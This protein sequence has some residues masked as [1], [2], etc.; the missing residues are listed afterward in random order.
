MAKVIVSRPSGLRLSKEVSV[1]ARITNGEGNILLVRQATGRRFWTL[2][3]G[4]VKRGEGLVDALRREVQEESGLIVQIG[5]L[6]AVRD[7][8]EK[9]AITLLFDAESRNGEINV[10]LNQKEISEAKYASELPENSS[11]SATY[12]WPLLHRPP[13]SEENAGLK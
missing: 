3:G 9:A 10:P 6:V 2:P 8:P 7:R 11:P 4:K 13:I 12:F 1:M 5:Y